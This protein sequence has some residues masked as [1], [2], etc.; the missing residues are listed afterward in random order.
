MSVVAV[1]PL[2]MTTNNDG[3][4][5]DDPEVEALLEKWANDPEYQDMN[6]RAFRLTGI[7]EY[8]VDV[9]NAEGDRYAT[10]PLFANDQSL[11]TRF[12]EMIMQWHFNRQ[13]YPTE[14]FAGTRCD[15]AVALVLVS[16]E[17]DDI[18]TVALHPDASVS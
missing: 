9:I 16:P 13:L 17:G 7:V 4:R 14:M 10:V 1:R 18:K 5:R 6:E 3:Q 12:D 11:Y 15:D 8:R 2:G